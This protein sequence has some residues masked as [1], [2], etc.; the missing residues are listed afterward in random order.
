[1]LVG[2]HKVARRLVAQRSLT[3]LSVGYDMKYFTVV[4]LG[5]SLFVLTCGLCAIAG[6]LLQFSPLLTVL[7]LLLGA[8]GVVLTVDLLQAWLFG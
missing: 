2:I 5:I 1:M 3:P 8:L 6:L 4:L 7:V